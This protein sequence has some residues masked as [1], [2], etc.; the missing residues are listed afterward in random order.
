[1]SG[2]AKWVKGDSII[3]WIR[4]WRLENDATWDSQTHVNFKGLIIWH[5]K[6]RD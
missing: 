1:M 4:L 2:F 6:Y 5:S 3:H